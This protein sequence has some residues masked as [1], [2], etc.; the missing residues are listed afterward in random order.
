ML[1]STDDSSVENSKLSLQDKHFDDVVVNR[2]KNITINKIADASKDF[3]DRESRESREPAAKKEP[4]SPQI[5]VISDERSDEKSHKR[6]RT[7]S[8]DSEIVVIV[9]NDDTRAYISQSI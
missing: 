5:G 8:P 4:M 7:E 2:N 1:Q 9:N 6:K 3:L